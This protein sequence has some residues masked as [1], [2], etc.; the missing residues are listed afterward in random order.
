[1]KT[2]LHGRNPELMREKG[3]QHS[4]SDIPGYQD[5]VTWTAPANIALVKYWGKKAN[6]LPMNPSL[7]LALERCV[8]ETTIHYRFRKGSGLEW[9]FYFDGDLQHTFGK[10]IEMFFTNVT[11][12]L[13]SLPHLDI[14]ID[15]RNTFP[16]SAGIASS[17]S[18]MAA[19]ALCMMSIEEVF[20]GRVMLENEFIHS[21]SMLARRGSGSA[22]RSVI[23]GYAIW[24]KSDIFPGS[25]DEY[26]TSL[27]FEVHP[28][29][30]GINNA[31]LVVDSGRKAVS[32]SE[33]HALMK[34]HPYAQARYREANKHLQLLS[35]ILRRGD[36]EEFISLVE[37]EALSLH[38][39]MM[40]SDPGI[41]LMRPA[42]LE[43]INKVRR[44]REQSGQFVAFTLD[45]GP[46]VHLIYHDNNRSETELFIKRELMKFCE[47]GTVIP[48]HI[49]T[50]PVKNHKINP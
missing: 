47:E 17:A 34:D 29:F 6:Q 22:A 26:A 37:K 36:S 20:T 23:G 50:G 41:I 8:T 5:H 39:L 31:I 14:R 4:P 44:Y 28:F 35:N 3:I 45:A 25:A 12:I 16:H 19:L 15:S 38:A 1:M 11:G 24:G 42:T 9:Q 43:I 49:G 10:K 30:Y 21:A 48:D 18:S 2:L 7:S 32:S 33:G 40:S 46:N 13:S 27:P